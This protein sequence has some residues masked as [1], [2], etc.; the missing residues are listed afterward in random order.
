M[1]CYVY[2]WQMSF[3]NG[4]DVQILVTAESAPVARRRVDSWLDQ[5]SSLLEQGGAQ[6]S[7]A[8]VGRSDAPTG[9]D[10]GAVPVI[11]WPGDVAAKA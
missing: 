5:R 1:R 3:A 10:A 9:P 6:T 7:P 4:I 2:R 8:L 11:T